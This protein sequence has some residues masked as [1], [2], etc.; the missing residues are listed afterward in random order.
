MYEPPVIG[1]KSMHAAYYSLVASPFCMGVKDGGDLLLLWGY[2]AGD[3]W[4]YSV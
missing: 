2:L 3:G 1:V 4:R